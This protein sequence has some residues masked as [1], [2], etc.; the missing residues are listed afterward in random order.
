MVKIFGQSRMFLKWF[1]AQ[2]PLGTREP[3]KYRWY[4]VEVACF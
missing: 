4:E 2:F 3:P 1:L